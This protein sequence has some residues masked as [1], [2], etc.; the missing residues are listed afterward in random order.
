M[1]ANG[2]EKNHK[3]HFLDDDFIVSPSEHQYILDSLKSG[4]TNVILR[5]GNLIMNLTLGFSSKETTDP[6]MAQRE[7]MDNRLKLN[8]YKQEE[9]SEKEIE[10]RKAILDLNKSATG[11]SS[12]LSSGGKKDCAKCGENHFIPSDRTMCLPCLLSTVK[13]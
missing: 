12:V 11:F 6:T 4:K 13:S 1:D 7:E 9:L 5:N 10:Q 2:I 3:Y 8:P